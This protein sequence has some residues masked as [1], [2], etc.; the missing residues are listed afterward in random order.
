MRHLA[1]GQR[2]Y[3]TVRL[4]NHR[5]LRVARCLV[6]LPKVEIV[7]LLIC[8]QRNNVRFFISNHVNLS[9]KELVDLYRQRFAIEFFH[10][11]IKQYLGFGET[12]VRSHVRSKT[13]DAGHGRLQCRC[14]IVQLS[15]PKF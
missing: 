3:T 15:I 4:S 1:K 2:K 9:T 5:P 12:F 14:F 11:D 13:L 6:V 7:V 10:K 8:K